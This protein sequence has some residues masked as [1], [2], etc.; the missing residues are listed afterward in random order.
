ML[1][2]QKSGMAMIDSSEAKT[3]VLIMCLYGLT[4]TFHEAEVD[5]IAL[6]WMSHFEFGL[7]GIDRSI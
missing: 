7:V 1:R 5:L 4:Q 3:R 6:P 2:K